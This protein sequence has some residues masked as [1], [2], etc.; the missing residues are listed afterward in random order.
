MTRT[1]LAR[2]AAEDLPEGLKPAW[3]T[4]N[5]LT[6]NATFVEVFAHAPELL[7]F[8]MEDFYRD[9]FFAGRVENKLKQLARLRLSLSHGCRTC[10]LQNIPGSLE[11]GVTREQIDK[12]D[13][14]EN[15]PFNDEEKA[16]LA[17][18]DQMVLTN[19]DGVMDQTL[20]RR[21]HQYFS[22]AEICE[23]GTVMAIIGGMA[24]LSFVMDLVDKEDSCPFAR[25][26]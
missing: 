10:N 3:E 23:L 17:F 1:P 8:V 22:D 13:D 4:L 7:K 26:E 16:V 2:I 5:G 15:G 20:Y 6:G 19:L 12:L 24:K 21:L 14:Y 18:A 9:I 25:S 11:A